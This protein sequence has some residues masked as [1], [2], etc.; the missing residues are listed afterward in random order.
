MRGAPSLMNPNA[1]GVPIP[2]GR[3][4]MAHSPAPA[5]AGPI[6]FEFALETSRASEIGLSALLLRA[7][8]GD[9]YDTLDLRALGNG[10]YTGHARVPTPGLYLLRL[11]CVPPDCLAYTV[12]FELRVAE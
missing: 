3:L 9:F 1:R 8:I 11:S 12:E 6:S 7:G 2:G 4:L 10:R 5:R